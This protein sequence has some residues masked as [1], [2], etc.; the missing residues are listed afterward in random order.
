MARRPTSLTLDPDMIDEAK[1]LG[2]NV[3]R[4]AEQGLADALKR[5][6]TRRWREENAAGMDAHNAFIERNGIPFS[7]HRKF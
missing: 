4:A 5:E 2:V 6:R 1:M 7:R 3:S